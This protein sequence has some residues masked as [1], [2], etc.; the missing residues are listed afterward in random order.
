MRAT[1]YPAWPALD[2]S[3]VAAVTA[4][5]RG[6][7]GAGSPA[8]LHGRP[9]SPLGFAAYQGAAP[10]SLIVNGTVTME[11]ACKALDIGWG[12]EVIVPALTFSATAYAPMAAGALPVFVDVD[13]RDLDD[14]SRSGRGRHHPAHEGDHPGAPRPSDGGHGP[15]HGD[16]EPAR[17][18]GDRGLRPRARPAVEGRGRRLHR[19]LRFVQP[20]VLQDPHRRGGRHAPDERRGAR[21]AR[22]LADRLR[23]R[24]G[25][26]TRRTSRSARTTG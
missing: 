2:D 17:T 18:G 5:V 7:H 21:P 12:D 3:D 24:E 14:R 20:S 9:S 13:R 16:R 15:D 19:Q 25:F 4:V 6:G 26:R 10:A 11:V 8:R 22:A 1:P 23:A